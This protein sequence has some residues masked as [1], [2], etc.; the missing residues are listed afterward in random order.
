MSWNQEAG[1]V[2]CLKMVVCISCFFALQQSRR[3]CIMQAPTGKDLLLSHQE[4]PE[5][6]PV[7]WEGHLC[8]RSLVVVCNREDTCRSEAGLS[9][10]HSNFV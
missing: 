7:T 5:L 8:P 1:S 2:T 6:L 10:S 9:L 3:W 4:A